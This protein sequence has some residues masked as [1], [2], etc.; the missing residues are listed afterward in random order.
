MFDF[1]LAV[2]CVLVCVASFA[3]TATSTQQSTGAN[4]KSGQVVLERALQALGGLDRL[5]QIDSIYLKGKG[6]EFRSADL[7]GP[8]P[9]TPTRASHE[10]TVAVL[11]SQNRLLYE[12]RT[13][14]HDGS[15]RW[16]RWIYAGEQRTVLDLRDDFISNVQ[17]DPSAARERARLS[18]IIPHL[19]L[20]EA[21]GNSAQ[22]QRAA[23]QV[24]A[25]KPHHVI[26][27]P[28]PGTTIPL[29]LFIAADTHLLSKYE[30]TM[31]YAGLGDAVVE[32]VYNAYRR[33]AKLGWA[34]T[35][36]KI[37]LAGK[38]FRE[39]EYT[40]IEADSSRAAAA[41]EI[42]A[43]L[44][45]HI[46][47]AGEVTEVAN[48]VFILFNGSLNPMF[49]EFKDFILAIEAPAQSPTLERVPADLQPGSDQLSEAFI[50]KI[51]ETVP[52]KPI[53]YLAVTH[54]HN[55]HAGGARAFM[56]EGATILTTPGNK[57]YFEKLA[58]AEFTVKPDRFSQ[59]PRP[60]AIETFQTKRVITDG[61]QTVEL[62]NVGRNPHV[63][64]NVVAYLP[65]HKILFQGDLFYF[66][67]MSPFPAK[68]PSRDA[69]M[70][71]FGNWLRRNN[72]HPERIYGFHDQGFATMTQVHQI[73]GLKRAAQK[74][75]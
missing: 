31:D 34:P 64:E 30:Y 73:L 62:L 59:Q 66:N 65:Q 63:N 75:Q 54:F 25:G 45:S 67:G 16:R 1:R 47:P 74:H 52:N 10:E 15:F 46:R 70:K 58:K 69:V 43:Q 28:L 61:E 71:F 14:R 21:A 53:R 40:Q 51:K 11:P 22:L 44:A 57:N 6:S 33:D 68:D 29:K 24:Y 41:F 19:L 26:T 9:D 27:F 17:R 12:H 39:I 32:F 60:L 36:Y 4:D 18:R 38:T 3:P 7:Q 56:A 8:D 23:D 49:V 20:I 13:A 5:K 35:G 55:D 42:P 72:L 50:R 48:G 2:I 37:L